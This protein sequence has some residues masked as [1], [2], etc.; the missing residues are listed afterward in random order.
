MAAAT[1][2]FRAESVNTAQETDDFDEW[3]RLAA[4]I[5]EYSRTDDPVPPAHAN[6]ATKVNGR[7]DKA[8]P[9]GHVEEEVNGSTDPVPKGHAEA[10]QSS[11]G[12]IR[13]QPNGQ[14]GPEWNGHQQNGTVKVERLPNF[15]LKG[16]ATDEETDLLG[17]PSSAFPAPAGSA[18]TA[19]AT[20]GEAAPEPAPFELI[21]A[22]LN[23]LDIPP[24]PAGSLALDDLPPAL[25]PTAPAQARDDAAAP[26]GSAKRPVEPATEPQRMPE[27]PASD[28]DALP[29]V[30]PSKRVGVS[31]PA[32]VD[33]RSAARRRIE[34]KVRRGA[35]VTVS[36][37]TIGGAAVALI[38]IIVLSATSVL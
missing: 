25:S 28:F 18:D 27:R 10:K 29:E 11:P 17:P 8:K 35:V 37:V 21:E 38:Y 15:L 23:D 19:R 7:D 33:R 6:D 30:R 5:G 32:V 14:D 34:R 1:L 12:E 3:A 31:T 13:P 9:N 4:S 24:P 2:S 22:L 26:A 16:P 20:P 36:G